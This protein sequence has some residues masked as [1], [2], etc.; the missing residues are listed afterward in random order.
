MKKLLAI[1]F[2]ILP[3]MYS[4]TEADVVFHKEVTQ[5]LKVEVR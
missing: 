1:I 3:L 5:T 4:C 2:L